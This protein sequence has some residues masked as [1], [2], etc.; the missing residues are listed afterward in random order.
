MMDEPK[1]YDAF[2]NILGQRNPHTEGVMSILREYYP[3]FAKKVLDRN[4]LVAMFVKYNFCTMDI[5]LYPVC[6]HCETLAAYYPAN[7]PVY[8]DDGKAIPACRCLKCGAVTLNPITFEDWCLMELKRKAPETI[9]FDLLV[10][11]DALADRLLKDAQKLYA[12][13]KKESN[14]AAPTR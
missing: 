13:A 9:G 3:A 6:G 12:K 5:L 14:N 11:R 4:P 7:P 10:A 2:R 8:D 1:R